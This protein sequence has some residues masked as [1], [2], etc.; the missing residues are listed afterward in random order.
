M[1]IAT[2]AYP[3]SWFDD[4]AQYEEKLSSWVSEAASNGAELL[5]F[6]EYGAMELASLSGEQAAGSIFGSISAVG[7]WWE[8]SNALYSRL[9]SRF[10]V[11][12]LSASAPVRDGEQVVN[13]AGFFAPSGAV[14]WQDKQIMTRFERDDWKIAPGG[15]LKLFDT[16]LGKIGVLICYDSE[17]PLLAKALADAG[18]EL[19]LVPSCTEA[20]EGYWRVRIG[21][22]AR[23]L[24]LQCVTAMSSL[25]GGD[26]RLYGI[27]D[28]TGAGGVFC[29][30]DQ[31]FPPTGVLAQGTLNA[32]G[33]TYAQVDLS[34]IAQVRADGHVLNLTHWA[35]QPPRAAAVTHSQLQ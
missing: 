8:A 4:W 7:E 2:A 32:P 12:I 1:K 23:A 24:E 30:P 18:A 14:D 26:P 15:P 17:F 11:H 10:G 35:E 25:V 16:A 13:R 9:S 34:A 28:N 21:S 19:I 27:E 6:P 3:P 20:L 22:M 5:V 29:P 33:W 31:G